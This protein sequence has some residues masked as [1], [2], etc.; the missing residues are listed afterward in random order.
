MS[1]LSASAQATS[2]SAR[3]WHTAWRRVV[4]SNGEGL[5]AAA[6][7]LVW[8][9]VGAVHSDFW[10]FV[11]IF[12]VID[13][14]LETLLFALGFLLI[15]LTGGMNMS[16]DAVGIFAG[17]SVAL[18]ASHG[19]FNGN[20]VVAVTLGLGIGLCLGAINALLVAVLKL[21]V[22]IV[23][24][25]TRA[26]YAGALLSWVGSA[27][28]PRMPGWLG[29]I[30]SWSMV[31]ASAKG[32]GAGLNW[33]VIPVIA[34]CVAVSIFLTRTVLGRSLYAMGGSVEGARRV[35]FPLTWAVTLAF[36]IGG[37]LAGLGGIIHVGMISSADPTDLV[38][39]ELTVVAA[40][41]IGGASIFGGR[42]SVLGTVLGVLLIE[43]INFALIALGVPTAWDNVALGAL[44]LIVVSLQLVGR[45]SSRSQVLGGLK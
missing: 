12:N 32:G 19:V 35:G 30:N 1:S 37:A 36:L 28:V 42:G 13:N 3:A 8:L 10:S 22:L 20:V 21:P 6:I 26:I 27:L 5:V 15:L 33:F 45:H 31:Y 16:F 11:T 25:G 24:L 38:G 39:N 9:F 34:I 4:G 2:Q 17:Y 14:S 29:G 18:M 40:V 41:V 43:L 7:V 44:I 23:T